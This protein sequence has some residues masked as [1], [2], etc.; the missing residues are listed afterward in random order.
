VVHN[1]AAF[2][3]RLDCEFEL[4]ELESDAVASGPAWRV[5]MGRGA[6][7]ATALTLV[8]SERVFGI[9]DVRAY[10]ADSSARL[11]F[12]DT[13]T[14]D[15]IYNERLIRWHPRATPNMAAVRADLLGRVMALAAHHDGHLVLHASAVSTDEGVVALLGPKQAGKSTLAMALVRRG[16]RLVT[17]DT[18]VIR[19][20]ANGR[21]AAVP[22]VQ[23]IRLWPDSARALGASAVSI[24][25]AKPTIDDIPTESLERAER[26]LSACY[27]V[28]PV[29]PTDS[30]AF[31]RR[32]LSEVQA[33]LV[34]ISCAKLGALG[35]SRLAIEMLDRATQLARVVPS[36]VADVPRDL[37]SLES[38]AVELMQW[39]TPAVPNVPR[40]R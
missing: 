28:H 7:P 11:E 39:H 34:A 6:A 17:D 13:G 1:Y 37:N 36:F 12:D 9:V 29:V 14:F 22:G 33:T 32:A 18:L 31:C 16:A 35:G 5:E 19:L 4:P 25:G 21:V 20:D 15:V 27:L 38:V 30:G 23:R 3:V 8:G 2:G 40:S 26:P 10:V 24:E